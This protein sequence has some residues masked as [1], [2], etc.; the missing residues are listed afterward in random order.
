MPLNSISSF[1]VLPAALLNSDIKLK[2]VVMGISKSP[3][4]TKDVAAKGIT[5]GGCSTEFVRLLSLSL[6]FT[7][8]DEQDAADDNDNDDDDD[9]DVLVDGVKAKGLLTLIK[10]L[11]DDGSAVAGVVIVVGV[12][13]VVVVAFIRLLDCLLLLL[14]FTWLLLLLLLTANA[15]TAVVVAF[16]HSKVHWDVV[17]A[18]QPLLFVPVLRKLSFGSVAVVV[19]GDAP[20]STTAFS[21]AVSLTFCVVPLSTFTLTHDTFV[22]PLRLTFRVLKFRFAAI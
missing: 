21:A 1:I 3:N 6:K 20:S 15:G 14:L 4:S 8:I 13:A 17:P 2:S 11:L 22:L 19:V 9:E 5:R 12:T 16:L 18:V 7:S 10:A